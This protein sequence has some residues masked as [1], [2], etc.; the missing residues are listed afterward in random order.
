MSALTMA[1][2]AN[3]TTRVSRPL[4]AVS[5][6]GLGI[7]GKRR[8]TADRTA[9]PGCPILF[10]HH[11]S[12]CVSEKAAARRVVPSLAW[13]SKCHR[14]S[15]LL[16]LVQDALAPTMG[17]TTLDRQ[18]KRARPCTCSGHCCRA[19]HRFRRLPRRSRRSST[20]SAIA[21]VHA[22][23]HRANRTG[24]ACQ[25]SP[26]PGPAC[27]I[28]RAPRMCCD[29][30]QR[31]LPRGSH[32]TLPQQCAGPASR[33]RRGSGNSVAQQRTVSLAGWILNASHVPPSRRRA[34]GGL[35]VA[36]PQSVSTCSV[37]SAL[38]GGGGWCDT[39]AASR[40]AGTTAPHGATSV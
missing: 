31:V 21:N 16:P 40:G 14:A 1:A 29:V 35:A 36:S 7:V 25:H 24:R 28:L 30:A 20:A 3:S 32:C 10:E 5:T 22:A 26:S 27:L 15:L 38:G 23:A 12:R 4:V 34:W 39:V 18:R 6:D 8:G 17:H 33:A 2:C 13:T 19:S 37:T 11:P 9:E